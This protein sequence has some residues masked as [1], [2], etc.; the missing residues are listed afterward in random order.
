MR[1]IGFIIIIAIYAVVYIVRLARKSR[2]KAPAPLPRT[3]FGEDAGDDD[4]EQENTP[5]PLPV[6][7]RAPGQSYTITPEPEQVIPGT[8]TPE[9][10]YFE[11][12]SA[13]HNVLAKAPKPAN[14]LAEQGATVNDPAV[15][16][17]NAEP[18]SGLFRKLEKMTPLARALVMSEVLGK[19]KGIVY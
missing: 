14:A 7:A 18:S 8:V 6:Q 13:P 19:P 1:S 4:E 17:A 2:A 16:P 15:K 12:V 5:A 11:Q 10:E 3:V 9:P